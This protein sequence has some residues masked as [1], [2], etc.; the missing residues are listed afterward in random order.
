MVNLYFT[1][2]SVKKDFAES[3]DGFNEMSGKYL[4]KLI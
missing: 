1:L 3:S 2:D 4:K